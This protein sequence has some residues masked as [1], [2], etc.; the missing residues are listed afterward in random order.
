MW[1]VGPGEAEAQE[2]ALPRLRY[3]TLG[4]VD[5][6]SQLG[7]DEAADVGHHALSGPKAAHVNV[8]VIGI[9]DEAMATPFEL[10]VQF[11]QHHVGEQGRER[12]TL[13]RSLVKSD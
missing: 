5:L 9:A 11:V 3:R 12:T 1:R 2:F 6:E 13:G 8:A 10:P 7:F 4:R